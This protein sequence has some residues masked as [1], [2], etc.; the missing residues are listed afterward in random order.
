M[1]R[2]FAVHKLNERGMRKAERLASAFDT[3][4]LIVDEIVGASEPRPLT[5]NFTHCVEHLEL[6]CFYAKK[7]LAQAPG[8]QLQ[9]SLEQSEL[10]G[11]GR[12]SYVTGLGEPAANMKDDAP[13]IPTSLVGFSSQQLLRELL[14]RGEWKKT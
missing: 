1:H 12:G 11:L 13:R 9:H 5:E 10:V 14:S 2:A 3:H 4:L 6:A 7:E 8:N